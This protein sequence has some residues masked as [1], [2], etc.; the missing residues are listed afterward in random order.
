MNEEE[1]K[2]I[3]ETE[4][5]TDMADIDDIAL[6]EVNEEGEVDAKTTIKKLREK[7]KKLEQEK[8]EY[9]SGW[10]RANADYANFKKEVDEK[11]KTDIKFASKRLIIDL[12]PTLDAYDMARANKASWEAV[13]SDWRMGIEYIFTQ[14]IRTLE[15]E[16]VTQYGNEGDLFDPA[17][18]ESVEN[19]EVDDPSKDGKI[20]LILQKGYKMGDTIIRVS[21]VKV[22]THTN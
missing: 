8:K 14:L 5:E 6:E 2:N 18:H 10:Q 1:V 3:T 4:S 11:R 13:S 21:R 22:F 9:L 20:A 16:G 19:I 17:K 12:L 15:N 7:I